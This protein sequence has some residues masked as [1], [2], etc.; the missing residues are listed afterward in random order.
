MAQQLIFELI[1]NIP[2]MAIK[3]LIV[4]IGLKII[5]SQLKFIDLIKVAALSTLPQSIVLTNFLTSLTQSD[6]MKNQQWLVY[7][8]FSLPIVLAIVIMVFMLHHFLKEVS[9]LKIVIISL[10]AHFIGIIT[11]GFMFAG[12]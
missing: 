2:N 1:Y 4:W 12:M 9:L 5:G 7:L 6:S 3:G 8:F 11:L 10:L